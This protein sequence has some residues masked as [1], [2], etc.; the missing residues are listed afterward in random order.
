MNDGSNVY[1]KYVDMYKKYL[2]Q[3]VLFG[4]WVALSFSVV[5]LTTILGTFLATENFGKG[6]TQK[7]GIVCVVLMGIIVALVLCALQIAKAMQKK[8][9][10]ILKHSDQG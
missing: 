10:Q 9:R 4:M 8:A 6:I 2:D 1:K 5:S 7:D 3:P